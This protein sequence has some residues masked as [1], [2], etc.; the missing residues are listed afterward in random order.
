MDS[1]CSRQ[2]L[3]GVSC[4]PEAAQGCDYA[5]V[6]SPFSLTE[7]GSEEGE[8]PQSGNA[9]ANKV[10]GACGARSRADHSG[11]ASPAAQGGAPMLVRCTSQEE[12]RLP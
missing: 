5:D 11:W 10:T 8:G 2:Y 12:G 7:L 9:Q 3:L 4:L 6:A 1:A